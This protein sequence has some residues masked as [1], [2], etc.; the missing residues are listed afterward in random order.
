MLLAE[1]SSLAFHDAAILPLHYEVSVW[2]ARKGLT[3]SARADQ[4]TLAMGVGQA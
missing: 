1:A 4:Y 3:Y 2:G